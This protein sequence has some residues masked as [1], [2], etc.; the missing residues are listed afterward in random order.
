MK[1]TA[2]Q[3]NHRKEDLLEFSLV[4]WQQKMLKEKP[5]KSSFAG[6]VQPVLCQD[7]VSKP[8]SELRS[9]QKN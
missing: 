2:I 6:A 9:P 1:S 4:I 7:N 3:G 5:F 8:K